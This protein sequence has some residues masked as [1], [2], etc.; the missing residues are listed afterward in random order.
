MSQLTRAVHFIK[1]GMNFKMKN[2]PNISFTPSSA[3][4]AAGTP[5]FGSQV[6]IEYGSFKLL[7]LLRTCQHQLGYGTVTF[8]GGP[9]IT[10]S[11]LGMVPNIIVYGS[12]P[13]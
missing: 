5:S 12:T 6:S 11:K 9:N 2:V 7:L 13:V 10:F 1:Q 4:I 8:K 3:V